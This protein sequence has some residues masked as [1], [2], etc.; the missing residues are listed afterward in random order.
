MQDFYTHYG[1]CLPPRKIDGNNDPIPRGVITY[2]GS[3]INSNRSTSRFV[4]GKYLKELNGKLESYVS[5]LYSIPIDI[6]FD[7]EL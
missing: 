7:C 6:T 4:Q 1:D 3:T 5:Y 2:T